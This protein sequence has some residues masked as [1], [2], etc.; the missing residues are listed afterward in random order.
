VKSPNLIT[1]SNFKTMWC[2]YALDFITGCNTNMG[3]RTNL[4]DEPRSNCIGRKCPALVLTMRDP[5]NDDW[6]G[7]CGKD[8]PMYIMTTD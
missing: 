4:Y 1:K 2:S 7:Y 5:D 3:N 8:H 6:V